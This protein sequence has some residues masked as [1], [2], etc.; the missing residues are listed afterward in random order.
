MGFGRPKAA[1]A[2][3]VGARPTKSGEPTGEEI[4]AAEREKLEQAEAVAGQAA[5]SEASRAAEEQAVSGRFCSNGVLL[6]AV[7]LVPFIGV[8]ST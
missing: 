6:L 8:G 4:A 3:F 2:P 1:G 7:S 5:A